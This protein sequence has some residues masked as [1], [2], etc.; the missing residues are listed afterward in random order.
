MF[1]RFLLYTMDIQVY[2]EIKHRWFRIHCP[3]YPLMEACCPLHQVDNCLLVHVFLCK[4]EIIGSPNQGYLL[5]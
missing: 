2:I 1:I 4:D 5:L 3:L